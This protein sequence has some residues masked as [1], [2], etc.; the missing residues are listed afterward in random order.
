MTAPKPSRLPLGRT[1]YARAVLID[2]GGFLALA[3]RADPKHEDA[4]ACLRLISAERLPL[5]VSSPTVHETQRR[6]LFDFGHAEAER[7]VRSILDGS[8]NIIRTLE[9]DDREGLRLMH[10]YAA[11]AL[12]LTDAVNMALMTRLQIGSCFS[13]DRHFLQAGYIRIPPFHL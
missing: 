3:N 8:V 1:L 2:T 10:R 11:L 7:F 5:F 12:T 4:V 13:F 9:E 6:F